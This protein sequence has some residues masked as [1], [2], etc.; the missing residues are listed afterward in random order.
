[1]NVALD[2]K[3]VQ[4]LAEIVKENNYIKRLELPNN[5]IGGEGASYL[6]QALKLNGSLER[7]S[8]D[9]NNL[10]DDGV[11]KIASA[12]P[13][14]PDLTELSLANNNIGDDGVQGFCVQFVASK[15][16]NTGKEH[17]FPKIDLRNNNIG[18]RGA[19][20]ISQLISDNQSITEVNL[21]HNII[22]DDGV[23]AIAA[24]LSLPSCHVRSL[25]LA[26]N[27]MSSKGVMALSDAFGKI[28][29]E[30]TVDISDNKL[31]TLQGITSIVMA[32]ASVKL[33][34]S[35]FK[36]SKKDNKTPTT[37]PGNTKEKT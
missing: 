5:L 6:F 22:G 18:D 24:N 34:Y 31:V 20:A 3:G 35:L 11:L 28:S 10:K 36:V 12:L 19:K 17:T 4:V 26:H 25:F 16:K 30:F 13:W 7:L 33:N 8:L 2:D 21:D 14:H 23:I 29:G 27:Q 32:N 1:V 37:S 15:A 9:H